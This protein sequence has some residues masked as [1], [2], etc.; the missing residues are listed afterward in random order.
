[1]DVGEWFRWV[2]A[3]VLGAFSPVAVE[4][5]RHRVERKQRRQDRSD[6]FQRETLLNLQ[7]AS[8]T[9]A[10]LVAQTHMLIQADQPISDQHAELQRIASLE[11]S[12]FGVRIYD[13]DVRQSV[14]RFQNVVSR[15]SL[16]PYDANHE[17]LKT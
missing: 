5:T 8:A 12:K 3:F 6:D 15:I 14:T 7:D 10:R 16:V 4:L 13:D 2:S 17:T 11:V 1:M 9:L